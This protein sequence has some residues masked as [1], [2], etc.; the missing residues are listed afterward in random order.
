MAD[1]GVGL[2]LLE[3]A[4]GLLKCD[5]LGGGGATG[6]VGWLKQGGWV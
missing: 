5:R 1:P 3:H 6:M 2:E 4:V